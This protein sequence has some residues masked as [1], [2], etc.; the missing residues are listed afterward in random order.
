MAME[1]NKI[2]KNLDIGVDWIGLRQISETNTKV[3]IRNGRPDSN[4]HS[5]DNGIMVEVL[6]DGMFGYAAT[7][8]LTQEGIFKAA[9]L[10]KKN[11]Q[12][13]STNKIYKFDESLRSK[14]QGNFISPFVKDL[15]QLSLSELNDF[16][17]IC[18]DKM[19]KRK[20]V[21]DTSAY[22]VISDIQTTFV[23]SN[24]SE[25]SSNIKIV[26]HELSVTSKKNNEIQS[27]S[28]GNIAQ[29][30]VELF[31]K[32]QFLFHANRILE[33]SMEL[34]EAS[35]CPNEKM[36][37][38]LMPD[39]MVL[40]IHESIGHPLEMDRILGD[41][42]NYAGW[43]FIKPH[44][45]GKLKYGS[46]LLN[47][48]FDPTMKSQIA[49]YD[50]DD[51]G[52]QAS[53]E[54]LIKDGILVRGLGGIESQARSKI[55]GVANSRATSWN[56]AP[57]DRMANI[58][59]EPGKSTLDEMIKSVERGVIMHTNRSWSIDDYRNKFQFGCELAKLIENGKITKTL[60]NPNY[61]GITNSF[62]SSLKMVGDKSTFEVM[63]TANCGKG[64]PNQ[65]IKVGHASPACL[66][67]KVEVFGGV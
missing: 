41:E 57:I 26:Q 24:G 23:S 30:G 32:E 22:A 62:W 46:N 54:Y 36:D 35:E 44:D 65:A 39:Q 55:P 1:L 11:A 19:G 51:T 59:L 17:S 53:K 9:L 28:W 21:M 27:R 56:R 20:E 29:C 48:T 2:I 3:N 61:R 13:F 43:S 5:I 47:I 38:I 60:K 58:N 33:E 34:L 49:S 50:F 18:C 6:K 4:S 67:S 63:G 8:D 37:L 42:R 40:Q 66:F 45:F 25:F 7:P 64:E 12:T 16:L 52:T 10:A 15:D 31:T 14:A